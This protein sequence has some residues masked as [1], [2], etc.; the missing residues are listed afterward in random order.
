MSDLTEHEILDRMKQSLRECMDASRDLAQH[1]RK[2]P[3]YKRLR[4]H[5]SL[6]E[7]CCK[8]LAVFREDARYLNIGLMMEECH[9]KAG[10]WLRGYKVNGVRIVIAPGQ[11]NE[12][13]ARLYVNLE[14]M[15]AGLD[16]MT[17]A[18]TG[19]RGPIVPEPEQHRRI[20]RAVNG[21]TPSQ[22][23]ILLPRTLH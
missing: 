4:E 9:K 13:F 15:L 6:V 14:A 12:M 21:Y 22:G 16:L 7:G 17:N 20:G 18:K 23:G 10:S 11:I 8:Q 19:V 2:G 1:S 3:S 5:L